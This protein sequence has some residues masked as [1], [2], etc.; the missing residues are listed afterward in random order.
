MTLGIGRA[1]RLDPCFKV[2][3]I[4]SLLKH[5]PVPPIYFAAKNFGNLK[6]FEKFWL[7]LVALRGVAAS[8]V[9]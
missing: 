9:P 3:F 2:T 7:E 6:K 4:D 5:D 1:G 8:V